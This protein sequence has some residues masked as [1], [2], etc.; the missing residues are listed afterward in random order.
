MPKIE[1]DSLLEE[2]PWFYQYF[3]KNPKSLISKIY[4]MFKIQYREL[5][6][7]Y[8]ILVMKN[9][10]GCHQRQIKRIYDMKGSTDD[11]QVL[12]DSDSLSE[13]HQHQVLKDLDFIAIE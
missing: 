12:R 13:V 9:I 1:F 4:G 3:E 2:L 7:E 5:E 11:R 6:R 8:Y 10:S